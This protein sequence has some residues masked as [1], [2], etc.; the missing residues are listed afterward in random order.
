MMAS[1]ALNEKPEDVPTKKLA[2]SILIK[3]LHF[4]QDFNL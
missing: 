4:V 1:V 2:V 3:I